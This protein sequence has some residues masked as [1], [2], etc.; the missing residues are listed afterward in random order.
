VHAKRYGGAAAA[1][2]EALNGSLNM[3]NEDLRICFI[4]D[5]FVNGTND[6]E[7]LGWTG[8][9]AASTRRKGYNL[10]SYN[11]GIRREASNDI[12]QRWLHEARLR[13]PDGCKPFVVFSF[14]VN[15]TTL[16]GGKVRIAEAQ[17][18]E[19]TH[20]IL[21]TAKQL[22]SVLLIG[23]PPIADTNQ[24]VRISRLS[25]LLS[26]VAAD[27]RVP[28]LPIFKPLRQDAV[29]MT[30]VSADDGA[31]PRAEGYTRLAALVEAW[32][33]WWFR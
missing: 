12:A 14:G 2:A 10:T 1:E 20:Q 5:S 17:S 11:L 30:E 21:S 29:W 22:Y 25:D 31:H 3:K 15:D 8:R 28:Y 24:N 16:E 32:S 33:Q 6:P 27:E 26:A 23:P 19:N 18:V 7:C 9:V 4:G 13:L